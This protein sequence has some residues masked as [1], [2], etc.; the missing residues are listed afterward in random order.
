[1]DE[2]PLLINPA[3]INPEDYISFREEMPYAI[4]NNFMEKIQLKY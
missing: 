3:Y 1:M 2:T 4:D